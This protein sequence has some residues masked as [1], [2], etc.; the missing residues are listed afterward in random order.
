MELE[1]KINSYLSSFLNSLTVIPASLIIPPPS[2]CIDG[3]CTR[4]DDNSLSI[5]HGDVLTFTNNP[6]P[7]FLERADS[8]AMIDAL[9]LWHELTPEPLRDE[10]SCPP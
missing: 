1:V 5:G 2:E 7:R 8:A 6:K 10:R 9:K 4:D 3:V